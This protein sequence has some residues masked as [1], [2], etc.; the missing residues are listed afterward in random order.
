VRKLTH[1]GHG[2][3]SPKGLSRD[4]FMN[5]CRSAT[6]NFLGVGVEYAYSLEWS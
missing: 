1:G 5:R 6:R 4:C 3:L 2:Y